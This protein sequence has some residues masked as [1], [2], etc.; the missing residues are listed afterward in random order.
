MHAFIDIKTAVNF[1]D[2]PTLVKL[3]DILE[4]TPL[5]ESSCPCYDL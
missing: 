5:A 2:G 3:Y 1:S 4:S